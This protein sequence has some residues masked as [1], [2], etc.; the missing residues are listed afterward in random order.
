MDLQETGEGGGGWIHL[1][2]LRNKWQTIVNRVLNTFFIQ[3]GKFLDTQS[4]NN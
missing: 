1:D 3:S 2:Q 4:G